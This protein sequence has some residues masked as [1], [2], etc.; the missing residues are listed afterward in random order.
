MCVPRDPAPRALA[1]NSCPHARAHALT[2]ARDPMPV[3]LRLHLVPESPLE[4]RA[5]HSRSE[6]EQSPVY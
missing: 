5:M 2:R 3:R 1:P 6:M 4:D